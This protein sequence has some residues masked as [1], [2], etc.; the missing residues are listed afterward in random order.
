MNSKR[1]RIDSVVGNLLISKKSKSRQ[2]EIVK[3]RQ[4]RKTNSKTEKIKDNLPKK[5]ATEKWSKKKKK[6]SSGPGFFQSSEGF[7]SSSVA[8]TVKEWEKLPIIANGGVF[9]SSNGETI[10]L[11][12]TC[13]IDNFFQMFLLHYPMNIDQLSKLFESDDL[14]VGKICN[15]VQFL[16]NH[17]IDSAKYYWLTDI[18]GITPDVRNNTLSA[19]GTDK[20]ILL[21]PIMDMF[22]EH[23]ALVALQT[24]VQRYLEAQ[25]VSVT[26]F[27]ILP[28]KIQMP[29]VRA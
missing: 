16:L 23:I 22:L 8:R 6:L 2:V 7:K 26:W 15:V 18:C 28:M 14:I 25:T 4:K 9:V 29:P 11:T 20:Q 21:H 24:S 13:T 5:L 1:E 27:F 3:T 19:F 10:N 12:N 17:D